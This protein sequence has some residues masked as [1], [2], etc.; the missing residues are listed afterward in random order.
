VGAKDA[1]AVVEPVRRTSEPAVPERPKLAPSVRLVGEFKGSGFA[2]RQWLIEREGQFVQVTDLLYRLAEQID[3][4]RTLDEIAEA[5]TTATDWAVRPEDVR[6]LIEAKLVPMRLVVANGAV[7]TVLPASRDAKPSPLAVNLRT[8]TVG[9]R[10]LDPITGTLRYLFTPAIVLLVLATTAVAEVW[11][12]RSGALFGAFVDALYT[13]GFLLIAFGLVLVGAGV[14][15]LGHASALRYGGGRPRAIGAGFY[16]VFPVFY[17]DVT[18]SYRL[19]RWGRVRTGLGGVYFHLIFI[20]ALVG[21]A[22]AFDQSFL[23]VAVVLV[24]LEIVRQFIPFVRLD[25]YWVLTDLTG[26]PDFFSQMEPFVRSLLPARAQGAR[27]PRLKPWAK[28]VFVT[29]ICLLIPALGFLLFLLAKNAPRIASVLWDALVTHTNI[30]TAAW[31]DGDWLTGATS[32]VQ[33]V[34]LGISGI[35]TAYILFG[36]VW[37]L[38]RAPARQ[39]TPARRALALVCAAPIVAVLAVLWGP[40][41]P[42]TGTRTPLGVQTFEVSGRQHV[43]GPVVYPQQPPVGGNH[44]AVW[45]NCGFYTTPIANENAVHSLEHGAVWV[46]YRPTL[47][48]RQIEVLRELAHGQRYVLVSPFAKLPAEVVASAWGRQLR[49]G[50]AYDERLRG[51]IRRFQLD[52]ATPERGGPCTGGTGTPR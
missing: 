15:E 28:A 29:Y 39:P 11:L 22:L 36:L 49:L 32:L 48:S 50:S 5:L 24:N 38:L 13:P 25:G 33:V 37:K 40:H 31:S 47:A 7:A 23:L 41:L 46:T 51:F 30:L 43:K 4:T 10:V 12:Y 42:F 20:L 21:A 1:T 3:G 45:Q 6:H 8:K 26:I 35:G 14:H 52:E 34:I 2:E 9:P 19:G 44:A 18:D 17:T 16:L 27:L